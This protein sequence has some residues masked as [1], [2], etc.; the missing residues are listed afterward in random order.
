MVTLPSVPGLMIALFDTASPAWKLSNE[1]RLEGLD[2]L[3]YAPSTPPELDP[4]TVMLA[5]IASTWLGSAGMLPW[6]STLTSKLRWSKA[7]GFGAGAGA[8][9][10]P[11]GKEDE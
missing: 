2:P 3:P 1:V 10:G 6:P 9:G 8:V 5:T 4:V 11:A 7:I